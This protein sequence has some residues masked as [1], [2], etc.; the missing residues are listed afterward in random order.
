MLNLIWVA[1]L[2]VGVLCATFTG[3]FD[4][5]NQGALNAAKSAVIDIALPLIGV[6]AL[7]LGMMRLAER[8][9]L[10]QLLGQFIRPI[11][12]RLFP[13]IPANHPAMG[14]MMM[15]IAANMLG[16]SNA[17]TPLGLKAMAHLDELNPKKGVATNAMCTFL[18][19]NTSSIQLVPATAINILAINGSKNPTAILGSTLIATGTAT[20]AAIFLVKV[21]E[22]VGPFRWEKQ[23]GFEPASV[24][25]NT[26]DHLA[27]EI[28]SPRLQRWAVLAIAGLLLLFAATLGMRAFPYLVHTWFPS[29]AIPGATADSLNWPANVPD[30]MALFLRAL[31]PL[32]I[33]FLLA[34]FP[35]YALG[36]GISVYSEF[37]EGAKEGFQVAIR[38]IPYLVGMLVAIA[39]FRESGALDLL[40]AGLAPLLSAI[41]IPADLLPMILMRPLSG[42]G[43]IAILG[44]LVKQFGPDQL[45]SYMAATIYGSA[46]TTFYVVAVYF[47]SVGITRTRHSIPAGLLADLVG[48]IAA[49]TVCR[50]LFG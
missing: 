44:D 37:V 30:A 47:G 25:E 40:K 21:L 29:F 23:E 8:A 45:L 31:S 28:A 46:E 34:F 11:M 2:V 39:V 32:A 20:V 18:A 17:A 7:W 41:Q 10:I 24:P 50:W 35:L 4:A 43:S 13:E 27:T 15:N 22:R 3:R 48:V 1:L 26:Q 12:R 5:L 36:K 6:M 38:I 16:V 33:P 14:A 49:I 19:L 42:S 9:G